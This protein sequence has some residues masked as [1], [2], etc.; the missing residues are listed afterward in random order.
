MVYSIL[1]TNKTQIVL[2]SLALAILGYWV[3]VNPGPD[4]L[5]AC[6]IG[7]ANLIRFLWKENEIKKKYITRTI[8]L[9]DNSASL[10][11][12]KVKK[13][14]INYF[15][16]D[17]Q[18]LKKIEKIENKYHELLKST[19]M[20]DQKKPN[21]I[22][23]TSY[24]QTGGITANQVNIGNQARVLNLEIQNQI[25]Q[26]LSK[27]KGKTITI[28][29]VMGDGEAFSFATH[30]KNYLSQLGHIVSGVEQGVYSE[31]I[32]G[33]VFN[34]EKLEIIIGSQK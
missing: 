20:D 5:S 31:P 24:N 33:Q 22:N 32:V 15:Q 4:S 12:A 26:M 9:R 19:K 21:K 17:P 25:Q 28:V 7:I 2:N 10:N 30:I 27:D 13:Q 34:P 14:V 6:V 3:Y 1:M 29:S 8:N 23:V 18:L 16:T 11:T